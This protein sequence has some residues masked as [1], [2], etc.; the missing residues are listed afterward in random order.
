MLRRKAI[1][2][3]HSGENL[4]A[5]CTALHDAFFGMWSKQHDY[6]QS[7]RKPMIWR[8]CFIVPS[9]IVRARSPPSFSTAST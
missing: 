3:F 8:T 9:A 2:L 1:A 6:A 7:C 4:V 5:R